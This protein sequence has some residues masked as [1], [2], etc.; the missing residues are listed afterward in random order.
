M[1][2][3]IVFGRQPVYEMLRA[4][5][6]EVRRLLMAGNIRMEAASVARIVKLAAR[7]GLVPTTG[8]TQELD[9][10]C[11]SGNHQGVAAEVSEYPY[12][13]LND[14]LVDERTDEPVILL[15]VDHIQD[16]QNLGS[17][18]RTGESAGI[19][20][21]VI[22]ATRAAE[23]TPAAVR[24]SAG[25]AEHVRV[26]R[27][28]NIHNALLKIKDRG[29]RVYGLDAGTD[30]VLYSDV[31]LSGP[32]ALVV[33]SEGEGMGKLLR[34]TCDGLIRLPM[35]GRI[36]SLNAAVAAAIALYEVRR[37]RGQP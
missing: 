31:D 20:G 1:S 24:A 3:D 9:R 13:D 36:G 21:V 4:A 32:L 33:G 27:V 22:P 10:I 37:Q 15:V 2:G 12:A 35:R 28:S 11:R 26:A 25:A 6:R 17:M 8:T 16:P 18:L 23:V 7:R 5:R 34:E 30:A 29:V 19:T 14:L